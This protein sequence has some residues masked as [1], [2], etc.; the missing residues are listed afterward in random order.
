MTEAMH[1]VLW[2][3][4][5]W[6]MHGA[7]RTVATEPYMVCYGTVATRLC[8]VC[9]GTVATEPCTMNHGLWVL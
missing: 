4:S 1:D 9:Y 2:D 7:L 8:M 6:T 5:Y 3:G